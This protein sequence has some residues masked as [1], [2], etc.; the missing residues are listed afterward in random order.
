MVEMTSGNSVQQYDDPIYRSYEIAWRAIYAS[1]ARHA[2]A[3]VVHNSET[4]HLTFLF[5]K[6]QM[7]RT[8]TGKATGRLLSVLRL[9]D[10]GFG[11]LSGELH[12]IRI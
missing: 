7:R 12:K 2:A 5:Y 11:E 6:K 9:A 4:L 3:A 8:P 10:I 1:L